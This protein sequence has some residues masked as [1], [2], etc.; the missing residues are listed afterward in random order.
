VRLPELDDEDLHSLTLGDGPWILLECPFSPVASAMDLLVAD[1]HRRGLRVLLAH[2]E[3]SPAFQREPARLARLIEHG[4]LAQITAGSLVGDFGPVVRRSGLELMRQGLAHVLA[5]DA[6][7][8]RDRPPVLS[9]AI[10]IL[11]RRFGDVAAHVEW[12][13]ER[14]PAAILA[15]ARLP[16]PPPLPR[17][18]LLRL[19][20]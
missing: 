17:R 7:D 11:Q 2:P 18:R 4:A 3:R 14:L 16:D 1:L 9:G 10:A 12:M 13:T 8:H 19:R 5:S 15:G 6:H 20:G